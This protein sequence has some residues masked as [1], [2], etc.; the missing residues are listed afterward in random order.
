MSGCACVAQQPV[1][2]AQSPVNLFAQLHTGTH[3]YC[4]YTV[5][6]SLCRILVGVAQ[7]SAIVA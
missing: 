1:S 5:Y 2:V 4:T 6:M 7:S 3:T